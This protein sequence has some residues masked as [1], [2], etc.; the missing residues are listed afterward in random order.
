MIFSI[1][2][3]KG[4]NY[5]KAYDVRIKVGNVQMIYY[6]VVHN[7]NGCKR[8]LNSILPNISNILTVYF[9]KLII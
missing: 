1:P 4:S 2:A 9:R 8:L 6:V 3:L 7:H 5:C